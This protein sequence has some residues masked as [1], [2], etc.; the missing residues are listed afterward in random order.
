MF[1]QLLTRLMF[2]G[3]NGYLQRLDKC[4]WGD[5]IIMSACAIL[6][7]VEHATSKR[8]ENQLESS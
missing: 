4:I 7:C 2:P 6:S 1:C 8:S 5:G 3:E